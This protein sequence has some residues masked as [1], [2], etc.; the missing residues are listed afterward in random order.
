MAPHLT[1]TER[2]REPRT[3]VR[4]I[5]HAA[6]RNAQ[7]GERV[8]SMGVIEDVSAGGVRMLA[9]TPLDR[10][11]EVDVAFALGETI[12]EAHGRIAHMEET[13][14]GQVDFGVEFQSLDGERRRLIEDYCRRL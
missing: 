14:D 12:V 8:E 13:R 3:L 1:H 6:Q 9:A 5:S 4:C 2:R 7:T 10:D 11:E